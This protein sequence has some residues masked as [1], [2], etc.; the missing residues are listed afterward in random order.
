MPVVDGWYYFGTLSH[1]VFAA[2][3]TV[4]D[5]LLDASD[6]RTDD[7]R[8]SAGGATGA[9]GEVGHADDAND[10]P[11]FVPVT[12]HIAIL[13]VLATDSRALT[14]TELASKPWRA[15]LGLSERTLQSRLAELEEAGLVHR[16]HGPRKGRAI[17]PQGKQKLPAGD[18]E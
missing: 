17:T 13:K 9:L 14:A 2:S 7:A 11:E 6:D 10:A 15:R 3:V 18:P 5:A 1:D 8:S 16:P 4:L 12:D